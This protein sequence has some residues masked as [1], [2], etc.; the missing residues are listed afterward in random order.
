MDNHHRVARCHLG[1][2]RV[3]IARSE[4][5]RAC[6]QVE[7]ARERFEAAEDRAGVG[8]CQRTLGDLERSRGHLEA[9]REH[10][11]TALETF[12]ESD[13]RDQGLQCLERLAR[14]EPDRY[15][16]RRIVVRDRQRFGAPAPGTH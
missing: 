7:T 15:R 2:G 16:K 1:R 10:W 11:E 6:E 8:R 4:H 14:E 9:A 12:Q 3:A 13:G 5:E